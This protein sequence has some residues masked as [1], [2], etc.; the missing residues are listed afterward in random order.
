MFNERGL[1]CVNIANGMADI[2]TADERIAVADLEA[3]VEVT[4]A[5]VEAARGLTCVTLR[6]GTVTSVRSGSTSWSRSRSTDARASPTRDMTGPV[7]VGDDR[8]RQRAG[9]RARA[10]VGRLRRRLREPD[11]RA[12][13]SAP[14][15]SHVMSLPYTAG[16]SAARCVEEFDRLAEGLDGLPV[17]CCGLHSQLA[18]VV[19][20]IGAGVRVAYAQ[21]AGGAL[22]VALSDTARLLKTR[23][24][25]RIGHRG[26]A[27]PRR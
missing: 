18:P 4:L 11:P 24:P 27:L 10:R 3:M 20:G 13:P 21:L 1:P 8:A 19:A 25:P 9:A 2:H 6:W 5:I 17:V 26:G 14:G 7:D 12:R 15:S 23:Q 22:P 16:Q